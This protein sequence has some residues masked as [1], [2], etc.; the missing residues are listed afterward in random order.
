MS[1]RGSTVKD[2]GMSALPLQNIK[3]LDVASVLAA[4]VTA[5]FLGDFGCEVIKVEEPRKGD[6]TRGAEPGARSPYWAQEARNKKSITLDLR[7][8]EGQGILRSLVPHFDVVVTNYRPPTLAKWGMMPEQ[9]QA[10]NPRAILVYITGYG[11][12]GP[13]SDRGAFD[14]VSSSFAGLTYASGYPDL[15]PVRGG[16]AV[17]DYMSSYLAAFATVTAL[18]HRDIGGSGEGQVIDLGLYEAGFR[19]TEDA[20][21]S[22]SAYGTVRERIGNRKKDIVPASDF[23]TADGRLLT[24]HAGTD[25]LFRKLAVVMGRPEMADDNRFA[26]RAA[27]IANPDPIYAVL[28]E[29]VSHQSAAD[30]T[31]L[32]S[33]AGIPATPMMSIADIS[34]DPHYLERETIQTV[35]DPEFGPLQMVAPLPRMSKT[36]GQIRTTGPELGGANSEIYSGLLG[37]SE[38]RI[39]ELRADGII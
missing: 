18:Y 37:L 28:T 32:L 9:L 35:D 20:I 36:P 15:P 5:T 31:K 21:T 23:E 30:A 1:A 29:W 19:A 16:Y 38:Q 33:A 12:T 27:R 39:A 2:A 26:T 22:Y 13:Y 14:R 3:V 10:I 24:V 11:L 17:I 4:P 7:T 8:S 34:K 6:F 25:T